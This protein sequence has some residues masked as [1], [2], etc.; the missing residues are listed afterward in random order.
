MIYLAPEHLRLVQSI[1][2]QHLPHQRVLVFGSR[3][4]GYHKPHSDLDLCVMSDE[5]MS[6]LLMTTL[7][8]AFSESNLPVRVDLV[9][10]ATLT[11]AFKNIIKETA[12][13]IYTPYTPT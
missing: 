11:S 13:P 7:K 9:D 10:W 8:E 1:L 2:K 5:P 3:A 4:I 6:L 12:L